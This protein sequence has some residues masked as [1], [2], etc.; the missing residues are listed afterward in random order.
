MNSMVWKFP[1]EADEE[2][3]SLPAGAEVIHAG[4]QE[5]IPCVWALC[6]SDP[7]LEREER[8]FAIRGTGHDV[9]EGA[10]HIA[11]QFEGPFVWHF[12]EV[13]A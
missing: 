6:D 1:F 8:R 10:R 3:I 11:S 9:P 7:H 5:G 4:R 2:T 12:F 13:G